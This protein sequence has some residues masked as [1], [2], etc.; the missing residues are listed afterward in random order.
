MLNDIG[1]TRIKNSSKGTPL[2]KINYDKLFIKSIL[3]SKL[4]IN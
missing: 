4:M 3:N 1:N 2:K